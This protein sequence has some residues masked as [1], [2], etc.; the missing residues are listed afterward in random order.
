MQHGFEAE[1]WE[2]CLA[3]RQERWA[4]YHDHPEWYEKKAARLEGLADRLE[5]IRNHYR[6][7]EGEVAKHL[8]DAQTYMR[9]KAKAI[10]ECPQGGS[11]K[12]EFS[13]LPVGVEARLAKA[14]DAYKGIRQLSGETEGRLDT[15]ING[16]HK[17]GDLMRHGK[18]DGAIKAMDELMRLVRGFREDLVKQ[19]GRHLTR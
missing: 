11:S 19:V 15:M 4:P 12:D 1:L 8:T 10:R 17:T 6:I 3:T 14:A 18:L 9:E 7:G 16:V 13:M 2:I 5:E